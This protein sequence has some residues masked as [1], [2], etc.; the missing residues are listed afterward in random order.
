MSH[1]VKQLRSSL[2]DLLHSSRRWLPIMAPLLLFALLAEDVAE[3][4]SFHFDAPLL[5]RLHHH[6]SPAFDAFMVGISLCGG[7][8]ILAPSFI[9]SAFLAARGRR[10]E[11][12]FVAVTIA[13]TAVLNLLAKSV[14]SR[15][16]PDLWLSVAPERDFS[17]PS[18]HSMMSSAFVGIILV[19]LWR[20]RVP[21]SVKRGATVAGFIFVLMVGLSRLY[22]GV[23]FPS[24]VLAGWSLSLAWVGISS[25][26]LY[27]YRPDRFRSQQSVQD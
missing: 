8:W 13:G 3:S 16:R 18:G 26:W 5:M 9:T 15:D 25:R 24:D 1:H 17:F 11:A 20:G 14:Y 12:T 7:V 22:L 21:L 6:A 19:L 2:Q 27:R 23:H 10:L 4:K